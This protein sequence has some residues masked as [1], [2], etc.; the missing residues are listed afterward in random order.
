MLYTYIDRYVYVYK[1]VVVCIFDN[2]ICPTIS[3]SGVSLSVIRY[4]DTVYRSSMLDQP[5]SAVYIESVEEVEWP[6][7]TD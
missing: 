1:V 7:T 2:N 6:T 5:L 3:A 4:V